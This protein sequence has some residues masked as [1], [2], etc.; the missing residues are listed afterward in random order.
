M[1][2]IVYGLFGIHVNYDSI[3]WVKVKNSHGLAQFPE[4]CAKK[5]KH[6]IGRR[7]LLLTLGSVIHS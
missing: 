1:G 7:D 4:Q 2:D 6:S 3:V 5:K